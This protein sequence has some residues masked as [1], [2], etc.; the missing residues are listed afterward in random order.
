MQKRT[1]RGATVR[2]DGDLV[3]FACHCAPLAA[4]PPATRA[5][6]GPQSDML[7]DALERGH[8][9]AAC[10]GKRLAAAVILSGPEA[11][12]SPGLEVPWLV[13]PAS[14]SCRGLVALLERVARRGKF[15]GA[16]WLAFPASS[17]CRGLVALSLNTLFLNGSKGTTED[18][19]VSPASVA[20]G[21]CNCPC[22]SS[23]Y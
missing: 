2:H 10:R 19:G 14:S 20:A 5:W 1:V 4:Q 17:S 16:P 15:L 21:C 13:F 11:C 18:L 23:G 22:T 3:S 6:R 9:V 12:R 8:R 7:V